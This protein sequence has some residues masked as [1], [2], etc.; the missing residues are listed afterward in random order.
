MVLDQHLKWDLQIKYVINKLR[1]ILPLFRY[2]KF[3]LDTY[4][5]LKTV[6][7]SLVQSHLNDGLLGSLKRMHE[8]LRCYSKNSFWKLYLIKTEIFLVIR[9]FSYLKY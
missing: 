9:F 5:P 1:G 7:L 8:V 3:S 2:L 4:R 6:Y